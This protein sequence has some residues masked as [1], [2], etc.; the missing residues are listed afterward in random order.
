M[1]H[2]RRIRKSGF[3]L[4]EVIITVAIIALLA[5]FALPNFLRAR[6]RSQASQLIHDLRVV[7][8]AIDQYSIETG[9]SAGQPVEWTDIRA[10]LKVGTKLYNSGGLDI[11]GTPINGGTFTVDGVPRIG[12]TTFTALS[13]VAPADFWSPYY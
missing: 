11:L 2:Q 12:T 10:Y 7:D 9:R 13:D 5:A 3:T 6:K 8:E 4:V 1:L